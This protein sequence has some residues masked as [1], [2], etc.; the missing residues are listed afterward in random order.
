MDLDLK[1]LIYFEMFQFEFSRSILFWFFE[2]LLSN[3][4]LFANI[5]W[6]L[7]DPHPLNVISWTSTFTLTF[8]WKG[9]VK[10]F[11]KRKVLFFRNAADE[12]SCHFYLKRLYIL[13]QCL[14]LVNHSW[15]NL[16]LL[17]TYF[18][19]L[20]WIHDEYIIL[21]TLTSC[22]HIVFGL[23]SK[24]TLSLA[25]V[26]SPLHEPGTGRNLT[27]ELIQFPRR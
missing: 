20:E 10:A 11:I 7:H 13:L 5:N 12:H 18:L 22:S 4:K 15:L 6:Y 21:K 16:S 27:W 24:A 26:Y 8:H 1:R 25:C 23:Q 19:V 9:K 17:S 14:V 3:R 2:G